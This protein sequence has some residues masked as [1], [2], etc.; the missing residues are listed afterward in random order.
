MSW[1]SNWSTKADGPHGPRRAR[2]AGGPRRARG[3]RAPVVPRQALGAL[4]PGGA[5]RA[6]LS[7]FPLISKY[8]I[9]PK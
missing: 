5:W 3:P 8:I 4:R 6:R 1:R 2:H 9:K 7:W